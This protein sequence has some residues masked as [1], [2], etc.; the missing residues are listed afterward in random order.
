MLLLL[1]SGIYFR[2]FNPGRSMPTITIIDG[3]P[4]F[5]L[6][7]LTSSPLKHRTSVDVVDGA[8]IEN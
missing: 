1:W 4:R 6:L 2:P 7:R 8:L 3:N 5:A